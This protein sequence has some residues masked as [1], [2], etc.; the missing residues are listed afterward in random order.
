[1][2]VLVGQ[3]MLYIAGS[4]GALES[5]RAADGHITF[6][7]RGTRRTGLYF[8]MVVVHFPLVSNL[9]L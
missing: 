1:M 5:F 8:M 6:F 4:I 7:R 3:H 9:P 2:G